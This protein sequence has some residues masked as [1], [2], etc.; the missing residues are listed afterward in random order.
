MNLQQEVALVT[1][2]ARRI[3]AAIVRELHAQG[4]CV[5]I[6]CHRSVA[7]AE[8]ISKELNDLR[9]GSAKV[10]AAALNQVSA[11][12]DLAETVYAHF[13]RLDVLV[14]NASSYYATPLTGLD[15]SQF[16]DLI[17]SNLKGPLFLSQACA[18]R[19]S[20]GGRII[21][22]LDVHARRPQARFSAYLS[23]KAGL[24]SV[25]ESL[26]L[27]LAP[28]VRV[29]GVAPGHM[30]WSDQ[31]VLSAEEQD[32]ELTRIPLSRLGGGAEIAN[33]VSFLISPQAAYLTGA[34]IPV[35][36][37]LRLN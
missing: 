19:M 10:V 17:A 6:H 21:N 1:G 2:G 30:I 28:R 9:P 29:N 8:E 12:K 4:M 33:A 36:G 5:A 16:D 24:W 37:G 25:T 13:G 7:A 31:G 35:D 20:D 26:A 32:A 22:L 11:L 27:E 14:N 34:I 15:E 23:A 3:G 18:A